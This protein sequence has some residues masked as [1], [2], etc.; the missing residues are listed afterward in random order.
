MILKLTTK[1]CRV[2]NKSEKRIRKHLARVTRA[3][4]HIESDLVVFRL[5][6]RKNIDR[7]FPPRF[8]RHRHKTYSDLK[9][10]ISYFEGS[11]AFRLNKNRFYT[12]FKGV[13]T[14]ECIN[15]GF[16]RLFIKLEKY[17]QASRW[18]DK[19]LHFPGESEYPDRRSIRK[20]WYG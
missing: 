14:D 20:G 3:L 1:N 2:S 12:H 10:A 13:T 19:D 18:R 8:R 15:L 17:K 9:P 6:I 11:I 4:P 7:Y 5:T 16:E